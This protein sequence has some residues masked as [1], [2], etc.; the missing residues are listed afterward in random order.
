MKRFRFK[1]ETL[2]QLRIRH[3]DEV[4]LQ[5]G[6]KNR[7]I[8]VA[9][10]EMA[11]LHDQ[12]KELQS[13]EKQRRATAGDIVQLRY[14]VAYRHKLKQDMLGKGRQIDKLGAQALEI[15]GKLV[16]ATR[17][18]RAIEIV[19]ERRFREWKKEYRSREQGFSDDIS[20]QLY[21]R[22]RAAVE[23]AR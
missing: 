15:R 4:K 17:D 21:I 18:R 5:L 9:R 6:K 11:Q 16:Q 13:S 2:L 10:K 1:L 7:E 22:H 12:L 3:E 23:G 20:Q 8:I 19:K 14:S